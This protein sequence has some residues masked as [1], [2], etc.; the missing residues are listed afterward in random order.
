MSRKTINVETIKSMVNEVLLNSEDSYKDGRESLT[1]LL[2]K[3]FVE[4]GNY[5]GFRYLSENDMVNS[6]GGVSVGINLT[7]TKRFEENPTKRFENTDP[8]RVHYF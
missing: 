6:T 3:I 7:E 2:E 8:T 1:F 4:T 5:R